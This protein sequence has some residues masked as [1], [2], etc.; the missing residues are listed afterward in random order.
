MIQQK[1]SP[2]VE[3]GRWKEPAIPIMSTGFTPDDSNGVVDERRSDFAGLAIADQIQETS[4]LVTIGELTSG[5]AHEINN[6]LSVVAGFAEL[7]MDCSLPYPI[8]DYVRKIYTESRRAAKIVQNLL[9]FSRKCE[10]RRE[11]KSVQFVLNRA[12]ELKQHDFKLKNIEVAT[13]WPRN[14]PLTMIFEHQLIQAVVNVLA[15]AEHALA[16]TDG[17][18][19]DAGRIAVSARASAGMVTIKIADNGPGIPRDHLEVVFD[20]F[21]T[22]KGSQDG[23]GLGLSDS[24]RIVELHGGRMW[25]Q[26]DLGEGSTFCMQIPVLRPEQRDDE[27]G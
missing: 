21:F 8:D 18:A 7:M 5:V 1:T 6:P 4:R 2:E 10:P 16:V 12:L 11:F 22:T 13:D 19:G 23:T 20:P 17:S 3:A 15:N 27:R 24:R 25:A 14:L 26:S 9:E